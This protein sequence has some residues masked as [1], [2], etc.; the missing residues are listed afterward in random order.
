MF[1]V[2]LSSFVI[3]ETKTL[4]LP[5]KHD[6]ILYLTHVLVPI[7]PGFIYFKT[8]IEYEKDIN[9]KH[10]NEKNAIKLCG[11]IFNSV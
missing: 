4:R 10:Q 6:M 11:K 7:M 3:H 8:H 1:I 9:I 2:F 5:R